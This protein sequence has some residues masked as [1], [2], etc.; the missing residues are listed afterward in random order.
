MKMDRLSVKTKLTNLRTLLYPFEITMDI[1]KVSHLTYQ[2]LIYF[3]IIHVKWNELVSSY[4]ST[5]ITLFPDLRSNVVEL[6][7][8]LTWTKYFHRRNCGIIEMF[9]L[10]WNSR[11]ENLIKFLIKLN[12]H[13]KPDSQSNSMELNFLEFQRLQHSC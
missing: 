2:F 13:K 7:V 4:A 11:C 8:L 12:F 1:Y 10:L 9:E 5:S 3:I 6:N